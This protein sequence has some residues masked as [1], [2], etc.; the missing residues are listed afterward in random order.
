VNWKRNQSRITI[1]MVTISVPTSC[2]E[3]T[4]PPTSTVPVPN[5]LFSACGSPLQ[6]QIT[7]PLTAIRSPIVTM[8]TRSTAPRSTGRMTMRWVTTPKANENA[9]VTTNAGQ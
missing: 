9:S 5:G 4:T 8:T 2:Q 3:T 1:P 6:C 7:K